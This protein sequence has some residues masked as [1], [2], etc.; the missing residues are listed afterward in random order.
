MFLFSFWNELHRFFSPLYK[1]KKSD[2]HHQFLFQKKKEKKSLRTFFM[3]QRAKNF[4]LDNLYRPLVQLS[5]FEALMTVIIGFLGGVFPVPLFTT[6]CTGLLGAIAGFTAPQNVIAVAVNLLMTPVQFILL[7]YFADASLIFFPSSSS[8]SDAILPS[9][10]IM[11]A[12][13]SGDLVGAVKSMPWIIAAA[14]VP[15]LVL[16]IFSLVVY[17]IGKP[18]KTKKSIDGQK[19]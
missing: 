16:T 15:W 8:S 7:P 14:C 10:Q 6:P 19:N 11:T 18:K 3:F 2:Q 12:L 5:L 9:Q 13:G 4:F 17:Q 1:R